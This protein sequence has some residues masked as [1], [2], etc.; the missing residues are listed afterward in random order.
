MVSPSL[1][2]PLML[3]DDVRTQLH[4]RMFKV[5]SPIEQLLCF[6]WH[7]LQ[8]LEEP[9]YSNKTDELRLEHET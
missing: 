1:E 7:Q 8:N 2:L 9:N 5:F 6:S 3:D 4:R